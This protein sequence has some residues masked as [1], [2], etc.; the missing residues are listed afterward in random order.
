MRRQSLSVQAR[1]G[2]HAPRL[3]VQQAAVPSSLKQRAGLARRGGGTTIVFTSILTRATQ[4]FREDRCPPVFRDIRRDCRSSTTSKAM[5]GKTTFE[6]LPTRPWPA[7]PK[8]RIGLS[9]TGGDVFEARAVV[10]STGL[11][12]TLSDRIGPVRTIF[13]EILFF[14][15]VAGRRRADEDNFLHP[16]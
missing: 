8:R 13:P 14:G 11:S 3:F 2:W 5:R 16:Y 12:M 4:P 10:I 9:S 1:P 6:F 15:G 7:Q